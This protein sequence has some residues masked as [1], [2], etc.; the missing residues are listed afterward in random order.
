MNGIPNFLK[1]QMLYPFFHK[2][3]GQGFALVYSDNVFIPSH[4]KLHMLDLINQL[5]KVCELSIVEIASEKLF[6]M[7]LTVKFFGVQ[8]GNELF[9]FNTLK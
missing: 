5:H 3:I 8:K 1:S 6:S 4:T 2:I 7:L 9:N